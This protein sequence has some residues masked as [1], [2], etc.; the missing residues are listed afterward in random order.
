[1]PTVIERYTKADGFYP[2][3]TTKFYALMVIDEHEQ[4]KATNTKWRLTKENEDWLGGV[5]DRGK[6]GEAMEFEEHLRLGAREKLGERRKC[7]WGGGLE[8]GCMRRTSDE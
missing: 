8:R 7:G 1:M 3:P 4:R 2:T 5:K 6:V